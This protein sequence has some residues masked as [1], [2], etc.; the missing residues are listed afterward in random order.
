MAT[1]ST[2]RSS[3]QYSDTENPGG[4]SHILALDGIRGFAIL[5]VLADHLLWSNN[6]TGSYV[7]DVLA[8]VRSSMFVGVYLFFT[9]S[10]F[11][12]TGILVKTISTPH[13]FKTFYGRRTLRIFPLYYT[14]LFI[15]IALTK[16]LHFV[17][18]GVQYY[19]LFYIGNLALW[20][21]GVLYL[22]HFNINHFWSLQV[23]EQFYLV[24]P[25]VIYRVRRVETLIRVCLIG[26]LVVLG[27]RAF[28]LIMLGLHIFTNRY[29]TGSPTFS[30]ADHLLF[31]CC[32]A[33]L[34]RTRWRE[35][36]LRL[37]PRVLL[38]SI[39]IL[40]A[41]AIPN[42]GLEP[43]EGSP[44][45]SFLIQTLGLSFVGISS[46]ALIAMTLK[47]RSITQ[48]LFENR[49]LRFFGK[50]S[51][52]I[53]VFHYSVIGF[54]GFPVRSF[55]NA[56]LHSKGLSLVCEAFVVGGISVVAAMLSYHLFE[57][58]FLRLKRYFSY[59]RATA[60]QPTSQSIAAS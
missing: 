35:K 16:P 33:I 51:Y 60:D 23:E 1:A 44:T 2:L 15:L 4:F 45:A 36:V 59:D 53:Y 27:I 22:G 8:R 50:Y 49:I 48:R 56:H 34:M 25:F 39:A 28:I 7:L 38:I 10:G 52:G 26:C 14:F 13:F 58:H 18:S 30:C 43:T 57:V 19:S 41:F 9:L 24:W 55:F 6:H 20:R 11:L 21:H 12:I 29:L 5:M 54:L 37:A 47:S 3:T 40:V 42:H 17:W 31:G 32:L 46:A